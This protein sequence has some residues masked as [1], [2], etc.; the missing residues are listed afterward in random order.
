MQFNKIPLSKLYKLIEICLNKFFNI[1]TLFIYSNFII[2]PLQIS[3]A[4]YIL[5]IIH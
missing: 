5:N 1:Y 4:I 2:I 3:I